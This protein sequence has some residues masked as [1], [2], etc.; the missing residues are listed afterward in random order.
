[1]GELVCVYKLQLTHLVDFR[2]VIDHDRL[3]FGA[4]SSLAVQ[5]LDPHLHSVCVI[6]PQLLHTQVQLSTTSEQTV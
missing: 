4:S 3:S 1:M 5:I 2:N 6:P